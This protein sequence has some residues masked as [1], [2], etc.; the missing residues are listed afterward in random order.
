MFWSKSINFFKTSPNAKCSFVN[1]CVGPEKKGGSLLQCKRSFKYAKWDLFKL[2]SFPF[3][4]DLSRFRGELEMLAKN[5]VSLSEFLLAKQMDN[6]LSLTQKEMNCLFKSK[7]ISN[8]I[9]L[10]A[11]L[12]KITL[13]TRVFEILFCLRGIFSH[14]ALGWWCICTLWV[15]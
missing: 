8:P 14:K 5:I 11:F 6:F 12:I 10:F 9:P 1:K 4:L 7:L 2:W 13:K 15:Y 3:A